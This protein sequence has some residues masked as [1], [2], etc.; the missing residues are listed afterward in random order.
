MFERLLPL[1]GATAG[2]LV[3]RTDDRGALEL[4]GAVGYSDETLE[5]FR[6]IPLDA[7]TPA[8]Q[9]VRTREVLWIESSHRAAA[10]FP[11]LTDRPSGHGAFAVLPLLLEAEATGALVLA[12]ADERSF[13]P[14]ERL[15]LMAMAGQ[16]AV[17]LQRAAAFARERASR[18]R[19]ELAL[20]AGT[21]GTWDWDLG[22]NR[23]TWSAQLEALHGVAPG[24]FGHTLDAYYHH[25]HAED[26]VRV[27]ADISASLQTGALHIEYR[28]RWPNGEVRW[29]EARGQLTRDREGRP[30]ALRGVCMDVTA[31]K[32]A[33]QALRESEERFRTL[34]DNIAPFAWM[35]DATG[36]IFWYSQRWYDYTGTTLNEIA[37][38]GLDESPP[39]RS[40]RPGGR[41]DQTFVGN[42]R[43]LGGH[44]SASGARRPVP[45]VPLAC[46]TDP[47]SGRTD[48]ALAGH[49][50]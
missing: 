40:R 3:L 41:P 32:Q 6:R 14:Q 1:F 34:A 13:A 20:Q 50:H 18:E 8:A 42:R 15:L 7:S 28:G 23:V 31:R 10:A 38:M 11:Y 44:L 12:F 2:T 27:R 43:T 48:R 47:R 4:V 9:V 33:E 45:L 16:C 30:V 46:G 25:V 37:R 19:L 39:S 17:A 35:A 5:A 29:F 49:Q 26:L 36:W 21:M 22:T 24:T